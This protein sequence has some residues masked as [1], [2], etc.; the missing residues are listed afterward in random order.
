MK[1]FED[2]YSA[3]NV[4]QKIDSYVFDN[5]KH[6]I[7][8][9]ETIVQYF[10][11]SFDSMSEPERSYIRPEKLSEFDEMESD[12]QAIVTDLL[13]EYLQENYNYYASTI[14]IIEENDLIEAI[15][16]AARTAHG[17][18][19]S[20]WRIPIYID[21]GIDGNGLDPNQKNSTSFSEGSWLSQGSWQPGCIEATAVNPWQCAGWEEGGWSNEEEFDENDQIESELDEWFNSN[22]VSYKDEVRTALEEYFQDNEI[23][24]Y[25]IIFK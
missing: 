3:K 9:G 25:Q 5:R 13:Y 14:I 7:E 18:E 23:E 15:K 8:F 17:S 20:G 2:Y 24:N 19:L 22:I 6:I 16:E 11:E 1:S 21:F 10:R 12:E 4:S